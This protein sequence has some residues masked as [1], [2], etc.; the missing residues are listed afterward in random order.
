MANE[1]VVLKVKTP[2]D[3]ICLGIV[4]PEHILKTLGWKTDQPVHLRVVGDTLYVDAR[5][6]S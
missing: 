5:V 3:K 2:D 6:I 4:I 1:S